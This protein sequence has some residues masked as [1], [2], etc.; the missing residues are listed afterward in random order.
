MDPELWYRLEGKDNEG[1]MSRTFRF[2]SW[3][4]LM[5]FVMRVGVIAEEMDHHP[6]VKFRF[7]VVTITTTTH[8]EG[9]SI[10]ELDIKFAN[11]V[12]SEYMP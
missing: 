12:N 1:Q 10:T 8:D 4:K 11:A 3:R 9:N 2:D 5:A 7:G 6:V